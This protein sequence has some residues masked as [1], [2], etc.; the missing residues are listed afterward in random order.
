MRLLHNWWNHNA[1]SPENE[2]L[3][4][5]ST[6]VRL[7]A[8]YNDSKRRNIWHWS[9]Y[10]TDSSVQKI[11]QTQNASVVTDASRILKTLLTKIKRSE[12]RDGVDGVSLILEKRDA[13]GRI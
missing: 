9:Y 7:F 1:T 3:L 12:L 8:R 10:A 4:D 2:N 13:T 5:S 6:I 11:K